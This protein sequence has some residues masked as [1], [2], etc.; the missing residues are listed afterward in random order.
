QGYITS[1]EDTTYTAGEGLDLDG[2]EFSLTQ[3]VL[4]AIS[5]AHTHANKDILD[6]IA[7][8]DIDNWDEAYNN[9]HTHL[10]KSTLDGI[11]DSDILNWND[12]YD[13]A[14][15]HVNKTIL[16][17]IS[18]SDVDNWDSKIDEAFADSKYALRTRTITGTGSITGG[19]NLTANRTLDLTQ[20]TKS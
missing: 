7:Q 6:D 8:D 20:D 13:K 17:G 3:S 9:S 1:Y 2:N 5:K 16:D 11:Q 10:N 19:G 4:E 12:A 15:T 18:E 14:H